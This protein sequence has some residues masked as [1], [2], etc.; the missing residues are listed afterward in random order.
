[1]STLTGTFASDDLSM[2]G[3]FSAEVTQDGEGVPGPQGPPGPE[4]P[5]GPEGPEGPIGLTGPQGPAGPQGV[6]GPQGP[7]GGGGT[8]MGV[9]A[10]NFAGGDLGAKINAALDAGHFDVFVPNSSGLVIST[11]VRLRHACTIRFSH[12]YPQHIVCATNDKP[13]FEVTGQNRHW[14]I[15][16][17]IFDGAATNTPSCFLLCGTQN[18]ISGGGQCGDTTAMR[19]VMCTG[20]WGVAVIISI[21]SEVIIW[22]RCNLWIQGKGDATWAGPRATV[23][24]GNKDY[25]NVPFTYNRPS[26]NAGSCSAITFQNCDIRGPAAPASVFLLK[27]QVEDLTIIPTYINSGGGRAHILA[28]PGL[29]GSVYTSPRRIA[30]RGGGRSECNNAAPNPLVLMDG[31]N[32]ANA[33]GIYHLSIGPMSVFESNAV[34]KTE[35]GG[36]IYNLVW[37]AANYVFPETATLVDHRTAPFEWATIKCRTPGKVDCTGQTLVN[38]DIKISGQVLGTNGTGNTIRSLNVTDWTA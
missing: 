15:E 31:Q 32:A 17:G 27:G 6:P 11:T 9:N 25:W 30:I 3:T 21:S 34:V 36:R 12:R 13:V 1:M 38:C 33:P 5:V 14:M 35:N 16:G 2:T 20:N 24:I 28:E 8:S 29:V 7:S 10:M 26:T 22:E 37:D 18:D 23:I 19:E 4:G